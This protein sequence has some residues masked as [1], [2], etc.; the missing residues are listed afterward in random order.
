MILMHAK[1]E[2]RRKIFSYQTTTVH[3]YRNRRGYAEDMARHICIFLTSYG[4]I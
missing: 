2:E 4:E 1:P 3:L